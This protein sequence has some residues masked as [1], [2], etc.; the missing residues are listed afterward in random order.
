LHKWRCEFCR[1]YVGVPGTITLYDENGIQ[2]DVC[3]F[4]DPGISRIV[5]SCLNPDL[6]KN[7][8]IGEI[9]HRVSKTGR[10]YRCN[11]CFLCGR[12]VTRFEYH[13]FYP[14]DLYSRAIASTTVI[15][16]KDL[17]NK[18]GSWKMKTSSGQ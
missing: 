7:H 4:V 9:E 3:W 1:K 14:G 16:G 8:K 13:E 11:T 6:M 2:L 12:V 17:P 15:L 18:Y 5:E 10:P